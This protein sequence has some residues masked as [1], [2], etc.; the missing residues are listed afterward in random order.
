[1]GHEIWM[2]IFRYAINPYVRINSDVMYTFL[3]EL[4][5]HFSEIETV[6][7]TFC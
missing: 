4:H 1:M 5:R 7:N 6:E 3:K 2:R